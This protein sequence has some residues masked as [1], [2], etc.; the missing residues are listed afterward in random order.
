MQ[1][2]MRGLL[3]ATVFAFVNNGL[4][5]NAAK[6]ALTA[7]QII[8]KAIEV[9]GGRAAREKITSTRFQG[10]LE[11]PSM[12]VKG[13]L[14]YYAK[15]PNK[16]ATVVAIEGYG[17]ERSGFDGRIAWADNPQGSRLLEGASLERARREAVFN[18]E[19]K[20]R[21]LYPKV[22]LLR[23]DKVGD[24]EVYVIQLAPASGRPMIAYYDTETFL[25][26]RQDSETDTQ[27]GPA[28]AQNY[29]TDYRE[30]DGVKTPFSIRRVRPDIELRIQISKQENNV[31]IDD[32]KFARPVAK[33]Q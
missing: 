31:P 32:A 25:T 10:T 33:P 12:A 8:D 28:M 27:D 1:V 21:E 9:T 3:L 2:S 26:L 5:Q 15:A 4:A 29:L 13:P 11:I 24:R 7:E 30:V 22:D 17:E 14:D 19:L 20:W 16:L 6:P 18:P 23:R